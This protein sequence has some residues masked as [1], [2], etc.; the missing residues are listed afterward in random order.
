MGKNKGVRYDSIR[1]WTT[2][3]FLGI[4]AACCIAICV[5]YEGIWPMIVC[6]VVLGSILLNFFGTYY[7]IDGDRLIV[8]TFFIPTTYPIVMIKDLKRSKIEAN[9]LLT[10]LLFDS[11]DMTGE[12]KPRQ[13]LLSAPSTS[14]RNRLAITFTDIKTLTRNKPLIISPVRQEEF[15]SQLLAINPKIGV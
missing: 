15:I 11:L 2:W 5:S 12:G 9:K 7:R 6:I 14:M 1:D 4:A 8:Y 3:L 10:D 13:Q